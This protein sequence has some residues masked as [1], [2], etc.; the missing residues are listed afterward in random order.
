MCGTTKPPD[1]DVPPL[2]RRKYA[3][4]SG[5][6]LLVCAT[7]CAH[8]E[9]ELVF[10]DRTAEHGVGVVAVV[11]AVADDVRLQF[12]RDVVV[13]QRSRSTP[14]KRATPEKLLPPSFGIESM[15]TPPSAF[16]ADC[17]PAS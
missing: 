13:L 3:T 4:G 12:R 2:G 1:S 10:P 15:R 8:E 14:K 16:S 9:P 6:R 17:D 5:I 11:E 7:R